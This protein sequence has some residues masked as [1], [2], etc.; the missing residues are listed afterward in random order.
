MKKFLLPFFTL[1]SFTTFAD[2]TVIGA[3]LSKVSV[4][5]D[6]VD[7]NNLLVPIS[8]GY[9]FEVAENF[10]VIPQLR[11]AVNVSDGK[12]KGYSVDAEV[13]YFAFAVRAQFDGGSF[14][15]YLE[16]IYADIDVSLSSSYASDEAS[17]NEF[18]ADFGIG[19]K[20]QDNYSLE[21]SYGALGDLKAFSIGI[22]TEF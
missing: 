12:V 10:S 20:A 5:V 8:F 2:G 7:F 17:G 6:Q 22:R 21:L 18:G 3:S 16:P 1:F 11:Y 9:A 14:Y 15:T 4:D 13:D 19:F